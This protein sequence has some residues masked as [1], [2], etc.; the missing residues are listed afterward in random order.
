MEPLLGD[1]EDGFFS[2]IFP[3]FG[4]KGILRPVETAPERAE[5]SLLAAEAASCSPLEEPKHSR[6]WAF[7]ESSFS[8]R[9]EPIGT[10]GAFPGPVWASS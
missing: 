1:S 6:F 9:L 7:S 8:M 2:T 3:D 5:R 10:N 4:A